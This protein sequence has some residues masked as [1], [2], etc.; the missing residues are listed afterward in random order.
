MG[1]TRASGLAGRLTRTGIVAALSLATLA[2]IGASGAL[3]TAAPAWNPFGVMLPPRLA[4]SG[5]GVE[6]ARTLGVR[7]VRPDAVLTATANASCPTCDRFRQA[8]FEVVLTLRN[9]WDPRVPS[10]PPGD[11]E[12]WRQ[13]VDRVLSRYRPRVLVVENEENSAWFYTGTPEEYGAQLKAA[14][15]V[16]HGRG[17]PCTNGGL[18]S[19]L[20]ALLVYDRYRTSGQLAM[21]RDFAARAFPP[22][23]RRQLDS[24]EAQRQ[25]EKGKALLSAYRA[26]P[27][28]YVNFH[29][30][31]GDP[32]AL[33]EAVGYLKAQT[34]LAVLTNEVGQTSD[35]PHQ[36]TAVM[37]KIV[38]LGLPIAVW[39]GMDGPKARGLVDRDGNLRPTGEAF[40][41]FVLQHV[42]PGRRR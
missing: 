23:V 17:I 31:V 39:F 7:Y 26:A 27:V 19:T 38:E 20:V 21:A 32:R 13:T 42:A 1:R 22:E 28:D 10:R 4:A 3:T 2:G 8:G 34:G 40:R 25:I 33:E 36:T 18:V 11:L 14:C 29:W 30:Y 9:T 37:G 6:V 35:D 41:S 24:P 12:G 5:R 16:A 15:Q